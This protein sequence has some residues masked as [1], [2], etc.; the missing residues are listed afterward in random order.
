MFKE[1]NVVTKSEPNSGKSF[2]MN[3]EL[4]QP[5]PITEILIYNWKESMFTIMKPLEEDMSQEPFLWT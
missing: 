5:E 3:T 1:D 2:L 4:T